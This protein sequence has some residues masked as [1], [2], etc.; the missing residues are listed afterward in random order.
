MPS[1][2][3]SKGIRYSAYAIGSHIL[4]NSCNIKYMLRFNSI[5][6][7]IG[8]TNST[9]DFNPSTERSLFVYWTGET[10]HLFISGIVILHVIYNSIHYICVCP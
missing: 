6:F 10:K 7:M 2:F 1:V 3:M 5:L 8:T 9:F 4:K